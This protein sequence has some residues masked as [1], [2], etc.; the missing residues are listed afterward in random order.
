M[1]NKKKKKKNKHLE[2]V[3]YWA[4]SR[5]R[6]LFRFGSAN[7]FVWPLCG[8]LFNVRT[9]PE[10]HYVY[11]VSGE[12]HNLLLPMKENEQ[13]NR[14][15]TTTIWLNIEIKK[16]RIRVQKKK[17]QTKDKCARLS[18]I[19]IILLSLTPSLRGPLH[20]LCSYQ[21]YQTRII[22]QK[23]ERQNKWGKTETLD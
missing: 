4:R 9:E 15:I 19:H 2:R 17:T 20:L 5:A 13:T 14:T 21:L 3:V 22:E 23:R 18:A 7:A 1:D 6:A 8:F 10:V 11:I 16:C 12:R